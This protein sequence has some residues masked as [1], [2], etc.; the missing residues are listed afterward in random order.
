[1]KK[2]NEKVPVPLTKEQEAEVDSWTDFYTR[3][4]KN[5]STKNA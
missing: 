3:L 4:Y 2:I 5:R 1:M